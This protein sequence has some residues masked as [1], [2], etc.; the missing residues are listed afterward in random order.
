VKV[1][2]MKMRVRE[3]RPIVALGSVGLGLDE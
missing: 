2:E 3:G 1:G